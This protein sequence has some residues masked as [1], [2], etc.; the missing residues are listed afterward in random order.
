MYNMFLFDVNLLWTITEYKK[1][2]DAIPSNCMMWSF[3]ITRFIHILSGMYCLHNQRPISSQVWEQF[4]PIRVTVLGL[5]KMWT[6]WSKKQGT[7]LNNMVS[8]Y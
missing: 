1:L 2:T 3:L 6:D 8:V 5:C 4:S 7:I